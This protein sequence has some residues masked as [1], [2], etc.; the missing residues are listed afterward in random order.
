M[1]SKLDS[2]M[3]MQMQMAVSVFK[4]ICEWQYHGNGRLKPVRTRRV[5]VQTETGC[6]LGLELDRNDNAR[7]VKKR[8]QIALNV[9]TDESS[10]TFGDLTLNNDL[11]AIRNDSP[12]LRGINNAIKSGV[13]P[14]PVNGGLGG[15]YYFRNIKGENLA[16]VKPTDEEPFAPNNPKGIVRKALGQLGLKRS[17]RI[18]ETGFRE[19]AAYLLDYGHFANVPPTILV[20]QL[21]PHDF[22]AG[23][24]GTSSF[25]DELEYIK[26]LDPLCDS[27]LLRAELPM[28]REACLCVLVL[29]SIF[30][31]EA[32]AFGLCLSEIGEMMSREF[33]AQEEEPSELEFV[34]LEAKELVM[35]IHMPFFEADERDD[36][37]Q[38]DMDCK[39][40]EVNVTPKT[41]GNLSVK[42]PFWCQSRSM[43][44]R[45]F[46]A[47]LDENIEVS[48]IQVDEGPVRAGISSRRKEDWFHT[49][50]RMIRTAYE[51]LPT[52]MS[53]MKFADMNEEEWNLFIVQFKELLHP[54]FANRR[55]R[56]I[57]HGQR[58]RLGTSYVFDIKVSVVRL[59]KNMKE[60]KTITSI[61]D[62]MRRGRGS[63]QAGRALVVPRVC[64]HKAWKG[65]RQGWGGGNIQE[66]FQMLSFYP[67][68]SQNFACKAKS[69]CK[70]KDYW[71]L[72]LL[73]A[74]CQHSWT[75]LFVISKGTWTL[76]RHQHDSQ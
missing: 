69:S 21:I 9:P 61:F 55:S 4:G 74:R 12:L 46:L 6:V 27:D 36:E 2:P 76:P 64:M 18:G 68:F 31:Q 19:V 22:D 40:D 33:H 70:F 60:E 52:L 47:Q 8:L 13:D 66:T 49:A 71:H 48:N 23:D 37:L 41:T 30:L 44:D 67:G 17:V 11:S 16:I 25:Q 15:A 14:V 28:I 45:N 29:C 34:C 26:N 20:K 54:A 38:F 75:L 51:Q 43:N 63:L 35:E 62:A 7:I 72:S 3:Q 65:R 10:L 59:V 56:T 24:H 5:F 73:D 32:A 39:E 57:G 58:Q 50:S 53:F 1:A 42:A